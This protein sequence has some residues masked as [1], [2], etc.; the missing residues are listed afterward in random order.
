[1]SW[2]YTREVLDIYIYSREAVMQFVLGGHLYCEGGGDT[3]QRCIHYHTTDITFA[4]MPSGKG[5]ENRLRIRNN[6]DLGVVHLLS[7]SGD[8][9]IGLV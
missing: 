6:Q 4:F 5:G 3:G 2:A 8:L 7:P 1:M 9:G